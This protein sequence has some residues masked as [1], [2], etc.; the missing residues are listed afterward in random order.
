[1]SFEG[2]SAE[3]IPALID[4]AGE[5]AAPSADT[6]TDGLASKSSSICS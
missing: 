3:P 2:S 6:R 4:N 1:M 5:A